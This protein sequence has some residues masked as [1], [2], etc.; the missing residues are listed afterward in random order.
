[1]CFHPLSED[2]QETT[3]ESRQILKFVLHGIFLVDISGCS[4]ES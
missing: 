1:M 3:F 2:E 4:T